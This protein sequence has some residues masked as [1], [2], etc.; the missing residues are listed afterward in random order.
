[1]FKRRAVPQRREILFG[2]SLEFHRKKTF[3]INVLIFW[4][5][6]FSIDSLNQKSHFAS[7]IF[8]IKV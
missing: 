7:M 2:S 1:M 6:F 3:L 8:F 5:D 4:D